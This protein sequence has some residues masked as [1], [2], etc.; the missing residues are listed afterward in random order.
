[1]FDLDKVLEPIKNKEYIQAHYLYPLMLGSGCTTDPKRVLGHA[2][3]P[4]W[5]AHLARW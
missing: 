3:H 2:Q 1:M 4:Y 5:A